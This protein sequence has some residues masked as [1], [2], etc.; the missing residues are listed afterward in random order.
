VPDLTISNQPEP[1]L[2]GFRNLNPAGFG[3]GELV[4][5]SQNKIYLIKRMVSTMLTAAIKRQCSSVLPSLR[6]C[7]PVF[8]EVC[9]MAM[10]FVFTPSE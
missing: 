5:G 3:G 9:G 6:H 1:D 7:L 10:D 8:D 2:A 4:L